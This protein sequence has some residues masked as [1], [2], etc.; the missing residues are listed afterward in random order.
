M[1]PNLTAPN[2]ALDRLIAQTPPG[3]MFWSGT[4]ADPTA[5]CGSCKY[6]G[7]ETVVRNEAGNS[8]ITRKYPSSCSLYKKHTGKDGKPFDR[9]TTACKYHEAKQP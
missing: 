9:A 3:M 4:C 5:T 2:R 8:V 1:T 7:Y 6:F